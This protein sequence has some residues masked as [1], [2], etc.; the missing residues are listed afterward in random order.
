VNYSPPILVFAGHSR[1]HTCFWGIMKDMEPTPRQVTRSVDLTG[2]PE[3]AAKAVESLVSVL[4]E[5]ATKQPALHG[6]ASRGEW[7]KAIREWAASH[8]PKAAQADWN[9]ESI[10]ADRNE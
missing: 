1:P 3:D 7:V 5:H 4:R 2:L 6:F 8:T 9:R 10:Y